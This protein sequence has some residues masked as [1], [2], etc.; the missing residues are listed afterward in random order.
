M[1]RR[2]IA[3]RDVRHARALRAL[4]AAIAP[5]AADWRAALALGGA[6]TPHGRRA[7][8]D[9]GERDNARVALEAAARMRGAKVRAALLRAAGWEVT[10]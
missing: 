2:A 5:T 7:I 10:S 3:M 8:A 6:A 4:A 9:Y 1:I